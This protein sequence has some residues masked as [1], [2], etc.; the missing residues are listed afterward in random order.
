MFH[1]RIAVAVQFIF[2]VQRA[3]LREVELKCRPEVPDLCIVLGKVEATETDSIIVANAKQWQKIDNIITVEESNSTIF[4]SAIF[5]AF[6]L[7]KKVHINRFGIRK[8][9]AETF[10]DASKI[11]KIAL[12]GNQIEILPKN[13]FTTCIMLTELDLSNNRLRHIDDDALSGLISLQ[14]L[15]LY[16]NQLTALRRQMFIDLI[17]LEQIDLKENAIESIDEKTFDLPKLE[18]IF[19]SENRLKTLPANLFGPNVETFDVRDNQITHLGDAFVNSSQLLLIMLN[20]NP[21]EDLNLLQIAQMPNLHGLS[22]CGTGLTIDTLESLSTLPDIQFDVKFLDVSENNLSNSNILSMLKPFRALWHLNLSNNRFTT[23]DGLGQIK[24]TFPDLV[25][26]DV[27][28]NSL[29]C[30]WL[31][32]AMGEAETAGVRFDNPPTEQKNYKWTTCI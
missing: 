30:E 14:K 20:H 7:L 17:A 22:L 32:V 29:T 26:V 5:T 9:S 23:I 11:V 25:G 28:N 15:H 10:R 12:E 31:K 6:P 2:Y 16:R 1:F 24:Q 18:T 19:M 21:L 8:L 4:P 27:N 3:D 13:A